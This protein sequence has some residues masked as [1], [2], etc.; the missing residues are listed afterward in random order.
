MKV[1][2]EAQMKTVAKGYRDQIQALTQ[3]NHELTREVSSIKL[4]LGPA[5]AA[6]KDKVEEE[7]LVRF[8]RQ[9][10]EFLKSKTQQLK[11]K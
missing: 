9:M 1:D 10:Q 4:Q 3:R 8:D 5:L 7:L 2:F 6:L 11:Y